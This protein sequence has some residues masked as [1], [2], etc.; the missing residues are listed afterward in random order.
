MS[1]F[2]KFSSCAMLRCPVCKGHLQL[3]ERSL[4]CDSRHS[5]DIAKQGYVNLLT[6]GKPI[7]EYTKVSF[8]ERQQIL[9]KGMYA[10]LLEEICS[11]M[12]QTFRKGD[13]P[14]TLLD[15][16]CGEGY[17]SREISKRLGAKLNLEIYGTDLSRDSLQLA[18]KSEPEHRIR[19]FVAD[20]G[21]LPVK[22][23]KT[24]I[25][26][27]IFTSA[28]YQEFRRIMSNEGYIIK[29]IPGEDHVQELRRAAADQLFH[30]EYAERKGV[31]H[32]EENFELIVNKTVSR[33]FDV[34][35]EERDIFINMT[36]LLFNVDKEKIDWEQ[37]KTITVSGQLLIGRRKQG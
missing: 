31:Q 35:P 22:N 28:N 1:K 20:I 32:F 7:N 9:E 21:N 34:T 17:Y 4:A 5:F 6:G 27:D 36:P 25:I 13:K 15:A 2:L 10:H 29:I 30:K 24:D 3:K 37:V 12:E 16:G 19:W 18:A 8:Q 26:L 14:L 23:R 33:T 11:F